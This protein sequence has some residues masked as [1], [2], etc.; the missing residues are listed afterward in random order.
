MRSKLAELFN[1]IA[2]NATSFAEPILAHLCRMAAIEAE[3]AS[4]SWMPS[5]KIGIVGIWDWGITND[6]N[7]VDPAGAHFLGIVPSRAGKGLPNG[8]YLQALHPDD[9]DAIS[10][11]LGKIETVHT[12]NAYYETFQG[13][14]KQLPYNDAEQA[15]R[16][17]GAF[18]GKKADCVLRGS[19][20]IGDRAVQH[21]AA[22]EH[23]KSGDSFEASAAMTAHLMHI[24]GTLIGQTT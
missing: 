16:K 24:R 9:V 12:Q 2:A 6:L 7:R 22:T 18:Q 17:I 14:W 13:I 10:R 5:P 19:E 23:L 3:K 20:T 1:D 15:A 11:S 21:F 8:H 4:V